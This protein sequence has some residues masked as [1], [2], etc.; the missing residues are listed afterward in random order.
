MEEGFGERPPYKMAVPDT[1]SDGPPPWPVTE[2][3][4]GFDFIELNLRLI[5]VFPSYSNPF[6]CIEMCK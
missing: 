1:L 3:N 4:V 5:D 2:P 6:N